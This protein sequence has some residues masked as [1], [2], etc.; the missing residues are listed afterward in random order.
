VS[1]PQILLKHSSRKRLF[2]DSACPFC[3]GEPGVLGGT[4]TASL[5]IA[6]SVHDFD[7][8][9]VAGVAAGH[10]RLSGQL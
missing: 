1:S 5:G 9:G 6:V 3:H 10:I 7:P 4:V 2:S 8:A